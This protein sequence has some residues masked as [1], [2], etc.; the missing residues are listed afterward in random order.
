[1]KTVNIS[2]KAQFT[3]YELVECRVW[4]MIEGVIRV[5][6]HGLCNLC[7]NLS[8][9]LHRQSQLLDRFFISTNRTLEAIVDH[10]PGGGIHFLA[11]NLL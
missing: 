9:V 10:Q 11:D 8:S 3:C 7:V 5:Q 2:A 4:W 1:V 6:L